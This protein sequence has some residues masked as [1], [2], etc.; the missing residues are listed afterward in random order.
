MQCNSKAHMQNLLATLQQQLLARA[1]QDELQSIA[2]IA[3]LF[4]DVDTAQQLLQNYKS[5][6]QQHL[7]EDLQEML[8]DFANA[9]LLHAA[10]AT[11]H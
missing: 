2:Q 3:L 11:M 6:L 1:T 8:Q 7:Q 4:G 5:K 10:S 9:H